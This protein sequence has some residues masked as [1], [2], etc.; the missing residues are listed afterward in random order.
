[1]LGRPPPS[2]PA[3]FIIRKKNVRASS[4]YGRYIHINLMPSIPSNQNIVNSLLVK[5]CVSP[6]KIGDEK[7]KTKKMCNTSDRTVYKKTKTTKNKNKGR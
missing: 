3:F 7:E 1:L 6:L 5:K 4:F 2:F